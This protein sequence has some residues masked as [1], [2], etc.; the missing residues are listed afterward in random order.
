MD[1]DFVSVGAN[2][3]E[4]YIKSL[5]SAFINFKKYCA[6]NNDILK[7]TYE[8]IVLD[9]NE[10]LNRFKTID[11]QSNKD[12]DLFIITLKVTIHFCCV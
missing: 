9:I 11:K 10:N 1:M 7:N 12:H 5:I 8:A 2:R 6:S 4:A 3:T